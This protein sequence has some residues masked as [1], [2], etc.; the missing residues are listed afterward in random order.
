MYSFSSKIWK[1]E[2][3][4]YLLVDENIILKQVSHKWHVN[5]KW[6]QQIQDRAQRW[7]HVN[8]VTKH[9]R[10]WSA[11][12]LNQL[13]DYQLFTNDHAPL[14]IIFN[15]R[16]IPRSS[17][18]KQWLWQGVIKHFVVEE[19]FKFTKT[20]RNIY[21]LF[22]KLNTARWYSQVLLEVS[23]FKGSFMKAN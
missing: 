18:D 2:N 9:K 16:L 23:V 22:S 17:T 1:E 8:T 11:N 19:A 14:V 5:A 4:C 3:L 21:I 20:I 6:I 15:T 7:A 13:S 10:Q 12:F